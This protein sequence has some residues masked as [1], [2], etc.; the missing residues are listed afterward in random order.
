MCTV[1]AVCT[2]MYMYIQQAYHIKEM[3][4]DE[5]L[6]AHL[7]TEDLGGEKEDAARD[8]RTCDENRS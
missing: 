8:R 1:H 5:C 6:R 4:S 7:A 2:Y 3:R